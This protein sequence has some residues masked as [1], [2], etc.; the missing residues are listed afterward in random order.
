M[1]LESTWRLTAICSCLAGLFSLGISE[2]SPI[3]PGRLIDIGGRR[4]HLNCTGNGSPVVVA[5]SGLGAFSTDWALVQPEVSKFT[6][7]LQL[8]PSGICVER[9]RPDI[10]YGR[11]DCR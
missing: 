4:L 5:E 9:Q 11:G 8:R 1:H 3:P 2:P 10:R 6:T 7:F